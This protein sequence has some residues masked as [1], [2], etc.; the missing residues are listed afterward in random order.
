MFATI[1]QAQRL[2]RAIKE[3]QGTI[4]H[5]VILSLLR[6]EKCFSSE[7]YKILQG[8]KGPKY[9]RQF[10][11]E[12]ARRAL[13]KGASFGQEPDAVFWA[14]TRERC[15]SGSRDRFLDEPIRVPAGSHFDAVLH[16]FEQALVKA[17]NTEYVADDGNPRRRQ[18]RPDRSRV[19]IPE[20]R[21]QVVGSHPFVAPEDDSSNGRKRG[22]PA[23]KSR[24]R[25]K[26][27]R[28]RAAK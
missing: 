19:T 1:A 23:A 24:Q 20:D 9:Q 16:A 22:Y 13:R 18:P 25:E 7:E 17:A 11:L 21:H 6:Q 28:D 15:F 2:V 26:R 14:A 8:A 12:V 3:D 4:L 10:L 27:A 5:P